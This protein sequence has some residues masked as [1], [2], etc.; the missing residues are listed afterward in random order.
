MVWN[1][2]FLN[3]GAGVDTGHYSVAAGLPHPYNSIPKELG[4][5]N[6]SGHSESIKFGTHLL[7]SSSFSI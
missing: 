2:S 1:S 7:L 5:N 3:L 6:G 4:R